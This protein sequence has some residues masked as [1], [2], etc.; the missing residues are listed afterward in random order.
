MPTFI[1]GGRKESFLF[2]WL[3]SSGFVFRENISEKYIYIKKNIYVLQ[4]L[5]TRNSRHRKLSLASVALLLQFRI[6]S[7]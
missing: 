4:I 2:I 3:Y 6:L 7:A 1:S 5:L